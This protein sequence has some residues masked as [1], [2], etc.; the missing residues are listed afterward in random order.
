MENFYTQDEIKASEE[1]IITD[2]EKVS[3][4]W[5]FE[6]IESLIPLIQEKWPDIASQ[7]I[8]A[9][10]G[11]ID[12]LVNEISKHTGTASSIAIKKQLFEIIDSIQS[13]QWELGEHIEPLENQLEELIDELNKVLRPKIEAPIRKK[14][15]LSI[16]IAAGI[17]ILVGSLLNIGRK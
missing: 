2:P 12:E 7:T 8:K 17:G 13:N 6:K 1:E 11:S 16:A 10:K 9:T 5:L 4:Q 14:P 3:D 15:I